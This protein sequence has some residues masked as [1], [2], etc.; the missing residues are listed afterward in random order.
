MSFVIEYYISANLSG[1]KL[2]KL[3]NFMSNRPAIAEYDFAG[4]VADSNGSQFK[5]GERVNG[6]S[7]PC[8]LPI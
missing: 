1:Y 7:F 6:F 3:P 8:M 5:N 4:V 2:L